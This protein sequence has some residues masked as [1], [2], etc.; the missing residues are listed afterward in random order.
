MAIISIDLT[1]SMDEIVRVYGMRW[2][3]ETLFKFTNSFFKLGTEFQGSSFD[4]LIS[5][6]TIVF[7]RYLV[8]EYE[9]R[10]E[11]DTKSLGG[12]FFLLADEVR[13]LD[14]QTALQQLMRLFMQLTYA[15]IKHLKSRQSF[16]NYVIGSLAYLAI[17]RGYSENCA[18]K[19]E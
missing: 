13:D 3:I 2:S 16:V 12:L 10:Q 11:N 17:S 18:A 8:M 1:V 9:S 19:A 6:T 15:K 4:M 7:S 5:H 14:Y